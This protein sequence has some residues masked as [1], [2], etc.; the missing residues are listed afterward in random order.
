M[1]KDAIK[2]LE[3]QVLKTLR[4]KIEKDVAD[5]VKSTRD[6]IMTYVLETIDPQT[7]DE[8][9]IIEHVMNKVAPAKKKDL[10]VD[11]GKRGKE[12]AGKEY[13]E[14]DDVKS[15]ALRVASENSVDL[16]DMKIKYMLVYPYISKK[17]L[18]K[19]CRSSALVKFFGECDFVIQISG[20]TYECL[21]D[22]AKDILILHEL[23]HIGKQEK[24][25]GKIKLR[26][27]DHDIKD[28]RRIVSK[29]GHDWVDEV[30]D[31][32]EKSITDEKEREKFKPEEIK[33]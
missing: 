11:T 20:D 16:T 4:A 17:V 15:I 29:Y 12:I 33:W 5:G 14:S 24:K 8:T 3:K 6:E 31:G 18:G 22:K 27:V 7:T 28:F 25:N 9:D 21:T 1:E 10:S 32:V 26:I 19:C 2:E 23:M 30:Y 13:V